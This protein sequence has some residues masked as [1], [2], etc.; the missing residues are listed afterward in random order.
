M[1]IWYQ[2]NSYEIVICS[3]HKTIN[4]TVCSGYSGVLCLLGAWFCISG[5]TTRPENSVVLYTSADREYAVPILDAFDRNNPGVEVARQFDVEASKTLGLVTRI[6]Q[7]QARTR[8]DVFWNNEIASKAIMADPCQL[9]EADASRRRHL[10]W[11]CGTRS[12]IACQ[13]RAFA[14]RFRMA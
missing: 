7:E 4:F 2:I 13:Q 12:R 8:C 10:G 3:V 11:I 14:G 9:A 6:E 1:A 5:C